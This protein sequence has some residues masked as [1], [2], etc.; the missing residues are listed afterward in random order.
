MKAYRFTADISSENF[1]AADFFGS[2]ILPFT[3]FLCEDEFLSKFGVSLI[4]PPEFVSIL[5]V[6]W[7]ETKH[8]LNV[9]LKAFFHVTK[10]IYRHVTDLNLLV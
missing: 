9:K 1:I 7:T 10:P 4:L 3:F 6:F 8:S 5:P 2:S